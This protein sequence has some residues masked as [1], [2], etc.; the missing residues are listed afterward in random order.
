MQFVF[1]LLPLNCSDR[2]SDFLMLD[3]T[4]FKVESG[5]RWSG[6]QMRRRMR[7]LRRC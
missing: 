5:R 4:R 3:R 2:D 7:I 6:W 1:V